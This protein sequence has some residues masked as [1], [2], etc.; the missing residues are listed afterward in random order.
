MYSVLMEGALDASSGPLPPNLLPH[1][2]VLGGVKVGFPPP[3]VFLWPI[4]LLPFILTMSSQDTDHGVGE[5]QP[6]SW[7]VP[8]Q[9]LIKPFADSQAGFVT[10]SLSPGPSSILQSKWSS[11]Q[12]WG[13]GRAGVKPRLRRVRCNSG[14]SNIFFPSLPILLLIDVCLAVTNMKSPPG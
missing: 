3:R 13:W 4:S 9:G 5:G 10:L 14:N 8:S 11:A 7:F 6:E 1:P 12:S 2:H